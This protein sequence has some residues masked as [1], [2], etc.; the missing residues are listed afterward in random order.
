M[1]GRKALLSTF[2]ITY[3]LLHRA[4]KLSISSTFFFEIFHYYDQAFN[5][6]NNE[7]SL[8]FQ[9]LWR[10]MFKMEWFLSPNRS[11]EIGDTNEGVI[12]CQRV[13][14]HWVEGIKKRRSYPCLHSQEI[15]LSPWCEF[16]M[17]VCLFLSKEERLPW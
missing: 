2:S 12:L 7:S 16:Q 11:F 14:V 4:F 5:H 8:F 3:Q 17:G 6:E 13:L 1:R 10:V 9:T 15:L